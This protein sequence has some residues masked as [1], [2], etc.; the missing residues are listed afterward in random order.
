MNGV[1][2]AAVQEPPKQENS[3]VLNKNTGFPEPLSHRE[4][5][6]PPVLLPACPPLGLPDAPSRILSILKARVHTASQ[7]NYRLLLLRIYEPFF[8]FFLSLKLSR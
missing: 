3:G 4:F 7:P 5:S 6:L 8:F 2:K 1:V